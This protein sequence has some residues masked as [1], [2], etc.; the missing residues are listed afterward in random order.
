MSTMPKNSLIATTSTRSWSW[1]KSIFFH[2]STT[3]FATLWWWKKKL[4]LLLL[5][6]TMSTT[7]RLCQK[8]IFSIATSFTMPWSWQKYIF[9]FQHLVYYILIISKNILFRKKIIPLL[10]LRSLHSW[11]WQAFS[12]VTAYV[13]YTLVK[14]KGILV[15][16]SILCSQ[17]FNQY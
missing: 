6:A 7:S 9:S 3:T 10:L 14:K 15:F 5:I 4:F 11:S 13:H 8:N 2:F 16:I 12:F 17:R 1:Q